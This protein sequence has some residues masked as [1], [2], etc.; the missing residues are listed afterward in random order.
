MTAKTLISKLIFVFVASCFVASVSQAEPRVERPLRNLIS[1]N[2]FQ[3]LLKFNAARVPDLKP[4]WE[5]SNQIGHRVYWAGGTVRG[6]LRWHYLQLQKYSAEEIRTMPMPSLSKMQ[7]L[8]GID[9]DLVGPDSDFEETRRQLRQ[10]G[11]LDYISERTYQQ[12]VEVGGPTI[13][14]LIINPNEIRDPKSGLRHYY[15]GFLVFESVPDEIFRKLHIVENED[16]TKTTEALRYIRFLHNMPETRAD[17]ASVARIR[18]IAETEKDFIRREDR[19]DFIMT[20]VKKLFLSLHGDVA[21]SISELEKFNLLVMLANAGF[22]GPTPYEFS[23]Y[24]KE[25]NLSEFSAEEI[26]AA[27]RTVGKQSKSG[28]IKFLDLALATTVKTPADFLKITEMTIEERKKYGPTVE[29]WIEDHISDFMALSPAPQREEIRALRD[30]IR[31]AGGSHTSFMRLIE[32]KLRGRVI[33]Q[34][35]SL[36]R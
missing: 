25:L 15:D 18:K 23:V 13:E 10:I 35:H 8:G 2:D 26:K 28:L 3:S 20:A 33:R 30:R 14:K 29:R 32:S 1:F 7:L 24:A 21:R 4:I 17:E 22:V 5:A 12:L 6:F 31:V 9:I 34:C 16:Y 36:F 19:W 27:Y 11:D